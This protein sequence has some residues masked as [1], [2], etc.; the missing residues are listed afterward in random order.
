NL[1]GHPAAQ[2]LLFGLVDDAHAAAAHLAQDPE[3][4]EPLQT[5][6]RASCRPAGGSPAALG[7]QV[8][9]PEQNREQV[10]DLSGQLGVAPAIVAEGGRL[11]A[12]FTLEE[13]LGEHLDGVAVAAAGR[14]AYH[15]IDLTVCVH[16][17]ASPYQSRP[18]RASWARI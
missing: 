7:T 2:R 16:E 9:H 18:S 8:L 10:A 5:G 11:A 1:Q 4:A 17:H 13:F 6:F 12:A 3:V 15:R 14:R